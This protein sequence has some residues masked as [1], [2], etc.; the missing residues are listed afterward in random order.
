L[1]CAGCSATP[2]YNGCGKSFDEKNIVVDVIAE[3][4]G[5]ELRGFIQDALRDLNFASKKYRLTIKLAYVEK[6]FAF[7]T[8]GNANRVRQTYTADVVLKDEKGA[9]VFKRPISVSA[10]A[11][12]SSAQGEVVLSLY[13]RNSKALLKELSVRIVENL[14][15]FAK[16]ED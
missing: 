13:G 7:S 8:D 1:L 11:N 2:L 5:Q 14:R 6:P 16:Y 4:S 15:V 12:I 10:S 9:V 3:R